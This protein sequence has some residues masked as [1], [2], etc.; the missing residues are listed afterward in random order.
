MTIGFCFI[1]PINNWLAEYWNIFTRNKL[2]HFYIFNSPNLSDIYDFFSVFTTCSHI[3]FIKN[4]TIPIYSPQFIFDFITKT[5]S[6]ISDNVISIKIKELISF[7]LT[8]KIN[9]WSFLS[10]ILSKKITNKLENLTYDNPL[11]LDSKKINNLRNK[12]YLFISNINSTT[13]IN[14]KIFSNNLK[15]NYLIPIRE[16]KST[17]F[18]TYREILL[19]RNPEQTSELSFIPI[20]L[21]NDFE[22]ELIYNSKK[23][24]SENLVLINSNSDKNEINLIKRNNKFH[25]ISI[26]EIFTLSYYHF[27]LEPTIYLFFKK[28]ENLISFDSDNNKL[29]PLLTV[30]H[31]SDLKSIEKILETEFKPS[32]S[33]MLGS[34]YYF[35]DFRKSVRYALSDSD[36]NTIREKGGMIRFYLNPLKI[37]TLPENLISFNIPINNKTPNYLI[38]PIRE[39]EK[40][41]LHKNDSKLLKYDSI[42]VK[43]FK[44]KH[45]FN[46]RIMINN[47]VSNP[48]YLVRNKNQFK[49]INYAENDISIY[50]LN[51]KWEPLATNYR[52]L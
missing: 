49:I 18:P 21:F 46:N 52:I 37:Y 9:D 1:N 22:L 10:N 40:K 44:I 11:K 31:G 14:Y 20:E 27:T 43:P 12:N 19:Y 15:Q 50:K 16:I 8:S 32:K 39:E 42:L 25:W 48:E 38:K 45:K 30:Y 47:I 35:G 13:N 29:I 5:N 7:N 2:L 34:G 17:D 51:K 26:Y 41:Y 28:F 36:W 23:I 3:V 4:K 33:G 24:L 6:F